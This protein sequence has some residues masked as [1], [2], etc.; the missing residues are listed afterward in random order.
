MSQ[1]LLSETDTDPLTAR[2]GARPES[3]AGGTG[4]APSLPCPADGPLQRPGHRPFR[5]RRTPAGRL[6]VL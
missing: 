5:P 4:P 2:A 6:R 3:A 1:Q